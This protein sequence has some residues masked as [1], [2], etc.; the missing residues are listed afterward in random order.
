MER[1]SREYPDERQTQAPGA[2]ELGVGT[3]ADRDHDAAGL[4]RGE[5]TEQRLTGLGVED[6]VLIPR[7]LFE[8][9]RLVVD[10][11]VRAK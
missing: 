6:H 1:G 4:H 3:S 5:R 11:D 2:R 7:H 8:P 9:P 10:G